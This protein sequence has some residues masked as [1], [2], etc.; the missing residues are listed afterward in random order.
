MTA[1]RATKKIFVAEKVVIVVEVV[2]ESHNQRVTE[3]QTHK[4]TES[5]SY[6]ATESQSHTITEL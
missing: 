5:H 6:R 1:L 2:V 3:S 4:V